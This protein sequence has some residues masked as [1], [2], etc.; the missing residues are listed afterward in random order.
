MENNR[1]ES[2]IAGR[3]PAVLAGANSRTANRRFAA[4]SMF[5]V[6]ACFAAALCLPAGGCAAGRAGQAGSNPADAGIWNDL[7][8][9]YRQPAQKWTEALPVGNGRLGAMVFGGT[10]AER[11]QL[12][13]DTLWAGPPIAQDR[14]GAYAHIAEARKLIFEGKYSEAQSI[15]Q[16]EVMGPPISP[17][18][19][20]TLG[21]LWIR[22]TR[23]TSTNKSRA[24]L[25]LSKWRRGGEDDPANMEYLQADF[26]D[27]GWAEL[28]VESGRFVK[29]D[30]SVAP[31]KKAVFR[32]RFELTGE[33]I[34]AGLCNLN[35]GPI[36]D[37]GT[38]YLNGK[39]AG[40]TTDYS[41]PHSFDVHKY[42]RTG[43]N[44]I[45]AVVGNV[46][47][48]GGMTPSVTLDY[49]AAPGGP[50]QRRLDL[51]TAT[52]TTT[53]ESD[54]TTYKRE[55]FASPVDQVVVVRLIANKPG[56]ISIEVGL[57]RPVDFEVRPIGG[58]TLAM[59]GQA[60]HEGEHKG[61][62]YHAQL[63][64]VS[65][66]G[67]VAVKDKTISI[68]GADA[69]TLL[70][71]AATDYNFDDPYNPLTADLAKAC[72]A[73]LAAAG[74]KGF[75]R[76]RADHIAEHRR[77]FRRVSLD[78]GATDAAGRPTDER[79]RALS[80][81]AEDPALVSL[82]FQFG[83]YLLISC[84]RPGCMPSNLQGLWNDSIAAPWNA[85]YHININI[86]MNYWP[87]EVCNLSECHDPF[88]R[89]SEALVPAGRKT[90]RD[91]YNCRGFVAHHTTDAW[92]W[93]TPTGSV[94]YGMWPMGAA[95]C[96]QHFMEHYR[97]TGDK[98]FLKNRA[99]PILKEASLFLLDWLVEDPK[100]GKLVSGPSNSPE[101]TFEAPN[102]KKVNL[103]MGPSM[104]QE[105][106]WD[107]FT[108]LIEAA[109]ILGIKNDFIE[110]VVAAR[111][112]LALPKIGSDGRLMEWA[113]EFKE[114]EPGHRHVSHLF[115][116]HPGR[117]FTFER[118]PE[119]MAAA[120]K[121]I[122][123]R[124]ANGGGH[125]GWSRA[126]IINFWARFRQGDKA[127]ENVTALLVKS[128][129]PNLFD[130]HPPFQIDGNYG[131]CAGIA[132][133]LLQSHTGEIH[134]LPAL[135]KAWPSG[136]VKG[137]RAR[138]GF[139]VDIAWTDGK[140]TSATIRSLLG[141]D[142]KIRAARPVNVTC[143]GKAAKTAAAGENLVELKTRANRT[144]QVSPG[145]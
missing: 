20:Q 2:L 3:E 98:K 126:W 121:S 101:N 116:V 5:A 1:N 22:M 115:A 45:V 69:V 56:G 70:L 10:A 46:G 8:L 119:M 54:G 49:A 131:G 66:G 44:V 94:G 84:S 91:V 27:S 92:F 18:S 77:L 112:K 6:I 7:K 136:S 53:F 143:D 145:S 64:T 14:A 100:T 133:M 104:D 39:E 74:K 86:Q 75:E 118:T 89:L 128:T 65:D 130:N 135:P 42:L 102:G 50:Y 76:I 117:Q 120:Q 60:S 24:V 38:I 31:N 125:T 68:S 37:T 141:N 114:P 106:I 88:L 51:D 19:H 23:G 123:F 93:T 58:D 26:D 140:L 97:F 21:N 139:E 34:K 9:W 17:R 80:D 87:A 40:R 95:W 48:P 81:G 85:D 113:E 16:R 82:Y 15:I 124:L 83:R 108:N 103:S 90:A 43:G 41:K 144:Y 71:A 105:I 36:D 32:S 78:L 67:Q 73:Q 13:E 63:R 129:H 62:K 29:G 122:E 59:F 30:A 35:L 99:Y 25:T 142:C 107:T 57:D 28:V 132:E 72:A 137:L 109:E 79:L 11:I 110:Q 12:N 61:V 52:A 127:Q 4:A 134:L 138:G 33:E 55:V 47:G 111:E 96:T